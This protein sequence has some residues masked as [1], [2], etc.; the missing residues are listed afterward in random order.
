MYRRDEE[1]EVAKVTA[2]AIEAAVAA[3]RTIVVLALVEGRKPVVF[4]VSTS[5]NMAWSMAHQAI[6]DGVTLKDE[7]KP[8]KVYDAVLVLCTPEAILRV[9]ELHKHAGHVIEEL[10]SDE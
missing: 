3:V 1:V 9:S 7:F 2:E 10:V 6:A 5:Y 4:G 8:Y